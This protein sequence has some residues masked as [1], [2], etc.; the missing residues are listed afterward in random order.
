MAKRKAG[1]H[2]H[3]RRE[4]QPKPPDRLDDL[5]AELPEPFRD[6]PDRQI[7]QLWVAWDAARHGH[8]VSYL[9][10]TLAVPADIAERLIAAGEAD[11]QGSTGH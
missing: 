2:W 9:T 6:A 3:H 7:A 4:E 1:H 5:R 11:R 10:H 8:R